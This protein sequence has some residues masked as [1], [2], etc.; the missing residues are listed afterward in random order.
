MKQMLLP[1]FRTEMALEFTSKPSEDMRRQIKKMQERQTQLDFARTAKILIGN[2]GLNTEVPCALSAVL[3]KIDNLQ[4]GTDDY[5]RALQ[6]LIM[7]S[8]K[9][10]YLIG[11][12]TKTQDEQDEIPKKRLCQFESKTLAT[13]RSLD[14]FLDSLRI[15][16]MYIERGTKDLD[17]PPMK[18]VAKLDELKD[19]LDICLN[20]YYWELNRYGLNIADKPSVDENL[21]SHCLQKKWLLP[22]SNVILIRDAQY[23]MMGKKKYK[24]E[25]LLDKRSQPFAFD[26]SLSYDNSLKCALTTYKYARRI[27]TIFSN[28]CEKNAG[29]YS[30][31]KQLIAHYKE[32]FQRKKDNQELLHPWLRF[33]ILPMPEEAILHD[34]HNLEPSIFDI[35]VVDKTKLALKL[36]ETFD[37]SFDEFLKLRNDIPL[38]LR[39]RGADFKLEKE[40]V[41]PEVQS[42][43]KKVLLAFSDFVDP[44]DFFNAEEDSVNKTRE[45]L[46]DA[47][48][49]IE[50]KSGTS[51]AQNKKN[52]EKAYDIIHNYIDFKDLTLPC[53][54]LSKAIDLQYIGHIYLEGFP[55]KLT[56]SLVKNLRKYQKKK[57]IKKMAGMTKLNQDLLIC[58]MED[59]KYQKQRNRI[60]PLQRKTTWQDFFLYKYHWI[61]ESPNDNEFSRAMKLIENFDQTIQNHILY[62][63]YLQLMNGYLQQ[64][65]TEIITTVI[66][67]YIEIAR[68]DVNEFLK[69]AQ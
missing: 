41:S 13:Y 9:P 54:F 34:L 58:I 26:T 64:L 53:L 50:K 32:K 2:N 55:N 68:K 36:A 35:P 30:V 29:S 47:A 38:I 17:R 11:L 57:Q 49:L 22:I 43:Y 67:H 18:A 16:L 44:D 66:G 31:Q 10:K 12:A 46:K 69:T 19:D 39:K 62:I 15:T 61:I 40:G 42:T 21:L 25:E 8:I 60:K 59:G 63:S 33:D 3:E 14:A 6:F 20:S 27:K 4:E 1:K 7:L 28:W 65:K 37:L 5:E 23:Q 56:K 24:K 51:R 48:S 45:K 52:I